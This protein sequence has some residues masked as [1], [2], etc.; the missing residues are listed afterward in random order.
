MSEDTPPI[1]VP[2]QM[3]TGKAHRLQAVK[4]KPRPPVVIV[5]ADGTTRTPTAGEIEFEELEGG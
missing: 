2:I 1:A 5:L 3:V 4:G